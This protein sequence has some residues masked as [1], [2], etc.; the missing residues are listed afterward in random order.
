LA[1]S[2][3]RGAVIG[4]AGSRKYI[5]DPIDKVVSSSVMETKEV[6]F[7]LMQLTR[8]AD[9][10]IRTLVE[11]ASRPQRE[12]VPLRRIA[13]RQLIPLPYL[14]KIVRRLRAA[15][16]VSTLRGRGGGVALEPLAA[17]L[18]LYRIISIIEGRLALNRCLIRRGACPLER[19]CPA[20]PVWRHVQDVLIRELDSVTL[21]GLVASRRERRPRQSGPLRNPALP[22]QSQAGRRTPA[23]AA[24]EAGVVQG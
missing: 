22:A 12:V 10:A 18:T 20:H 15:G 6:S 19:T 21:A 14:K 24:P 23:G 13:T 1:I 7:I 3:G 17:T 16:V 9:Y 11:L 4:K 2:M 5:L 8:E